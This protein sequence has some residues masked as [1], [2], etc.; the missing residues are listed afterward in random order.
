GN[1]F[2]TTPGLSLGRRS[3]WAPR[4]TLELGRRPS[5]KGERMMIRVAAGNADFVR[6]LLLGGSAALAVGSP[7]VALAQDTATVDTT[8]TVDT[9]SEAAPESATGNEIV[10][11]ATKR[12][13]TLQDTPVAV[14]VAT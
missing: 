12:E 10:V 8:G 9:T 7:A 4:G 5:G 11:T 2:A 13:L 6:A 14:S 1:C 3:F